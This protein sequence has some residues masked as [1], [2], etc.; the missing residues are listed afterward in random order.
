MNSNTLTHVLLLLLLAVSS[1]TLATCMLVNISSSS[2]ISMLLLL[3]VP[4]QVPS[5]PALLPVS[6]LTTLTQP[7]LFFFLLSLLT[8]LGAEPLPSLLARAS[9]NSPSVLMMTQP[10]RASWSN[11]GMLM[12][13]STG[14]TPSL[15]PLVMIGVK[16]GAWGCRLTGD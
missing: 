5:Q 12:M 8:L 10:A 2:L 16:G 7:F 11:P 3:A 6:G 1:V 14:L 4:A 13:T 9:W 15:S